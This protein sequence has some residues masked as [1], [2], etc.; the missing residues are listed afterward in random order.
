MMIMTLSLINA[1]IFTL[2]LVVHIKVNRR[3][4]S[5]T[6]L[7][8]K[9]KTMILIEIISLEISVFVRYAIHIGNTSIYDAILIISG[10]VQAI[11]LFQICYF[12]TKKASH[13][14]Q[15]NRKIRKLMRRVMYVAVLTFLGF[16]I[17]QFWDKKVIDANRSELCK[18]FYFILPNIVNQI[19]NAFFFY[20]GLKVMKS[21]QAFNSHQTALISPINAA[22]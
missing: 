14:L 3:G 12:Y 22:Q 13:F 18:T 9:V 19:A 20:I 2:L 6:K 4:T 5:C 21:V 7:L 15:D 17:Y 16:A 10:F 8:M 1:I 11:I